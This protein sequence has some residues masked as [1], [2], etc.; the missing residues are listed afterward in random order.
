METFK[1]FKRRFVAPALIPAL[2]ATGGAPA[3]VYQRDFFKLLPPLP[4]ADGLAPIIRERPPAPRPE[5][6]FLFLQGV[7]VAEPSLALIEDRRTGRVDF[8]QEGFPVG[9]AVLVSILPEK[10]TLTGPDGE[11]F[12]LFLALMFSGPAQPAAPASPSPDTRVSVPEAV[13]A[14]EPPESAAV[15]PVAVSLSELTREIPRVSEDLGRLQ[16]T[17]VVSGGR[18]AGYQ[19]RNFGSGALAEMAARFGFRN[20]DIVTMVNGT[21]VTR[22]SD[23]AGMYRSVGPGSAVKVRVLRDGSEIDLSFQV[24]P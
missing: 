18:V 24:A 15:T 8:Y 17:P 12:T 13:A 22:L 16:V 23:I 6:D 19:V 11:E 9:E 3:A 4:P 10:V 14:P 20:G 2:L 5:S 21:A 7:I 1:R